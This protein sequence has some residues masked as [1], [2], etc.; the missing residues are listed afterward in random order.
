MEAALPDPTR[1]KGKVAIVTGAAD[2]I[3]AA[4]ATRFAAE[5]AKVVLADRNP[6][7]GDRAASIG[8]VACQMDVTAPDAGEALAQ[9]ALAAFGHVDILVNNAGIGGSRRLSESDDALIDAFIDT[10][11][12]AVLRITRGAHC[13][14]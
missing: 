7:V 6:G 12:K 14:T 11:L 9:V 1:F 8:G 4:A 13:L 5:G 10:D 2:G 3:G